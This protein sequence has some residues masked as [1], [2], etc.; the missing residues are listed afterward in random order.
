MELKKRLDFIKGV[1]EEATKE[2]KQA[3]EKGVSASHILSQFDFFNVSINDVQNQISSTVYGDEHD[4]FYSAPGNC[5]RISI[6]FRLKGSSR[7]VETGVYDGERVYKVDEALASGNR[8]K[9]EIE[10]SD[11]SFYDTLEPVVRR[12]FEAFR[13]NQGIKK[14]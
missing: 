4:S 6:G 5:S 12:Y 3:T 7:Y 14:E 1:L 10:N 9:D 13:E 8:T 2:I 11:S